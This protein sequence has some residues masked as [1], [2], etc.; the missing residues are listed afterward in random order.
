M[1]ASRLRYRSRVPI[2]W[3]VSRNSLHLRGVEEQLLPTGSLAQS[4]GIHAQWDFVGRNSKCG[5]FPAGSCHAREYLWTKKRS[6]RI[7]WRFGR[8]K[9]RGFLPRSAA[10]R[11]ILR[12]RSE[13]RPQCIVYSRSPGA[14]RR[15]ISAQ[16]SPDNWLRLLSSHCRQNSNS[17]GARFVCTLWLAIPV[18]SSCV[19]FRS[20]SCLLRVRWPPIRRFSQV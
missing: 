8:L 11:A 5:M 14:A 4:A 6:G 16:E 2:V 10:R 1:A 13:H 19:A 12:R 7:V 15:G 20:S 9:K 18:T 17:L 3:K